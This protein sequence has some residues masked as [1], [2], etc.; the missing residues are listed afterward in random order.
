[1]LS[2]SDIENKL[3]QT[4]NFNYIVNNKKNKKGKQ[5]LR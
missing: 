5:T 3:K 1:M 4:L 2:A